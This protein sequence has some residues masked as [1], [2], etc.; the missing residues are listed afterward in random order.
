LERVG[1]WLVIPAH[2]PLRPWRSSHRTDQHLPIRVFTP[3]RPRLVHEAMGRTNEF[4]PL[5][6]STQAPPVSNG[7]PAPRKAVSA[8]EARLSTALPL[9]LQGAQV[10]ASTTCPPPQAPPPIG[11]S[12]AA[13]RLPHQRRH[14][15]GKALDVPPIRVVADQRPDERGGQQDERSDD[16]QA[17]TRPQAGDR[18]QK[19]A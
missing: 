9:G 13:R 5:P 4:S 14:V 19:A 15:V 17:L 1:L 3:S 12:N 2:V 18:L 16:P 8:P 11:P 7:Q 10:Q 6:V